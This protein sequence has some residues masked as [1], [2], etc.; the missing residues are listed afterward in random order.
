MEV[1]LI[2]PSLS[3]VRWSDGGLYCEPIKDLG[4]GRECV[5]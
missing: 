1:G 2:F 3:M 5:G 4:L